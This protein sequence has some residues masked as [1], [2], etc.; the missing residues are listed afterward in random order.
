MLCFVYFSPVCLCQLQNLPDLHGALQRINNLLYRWAG[1]GSPPNWLPFFLHAACG[2]EID[3]QSAL[4]PIYDFNAFGPFTFQPARVNVH[5]FGL[6]FEEQFIFLNGGDP[7]ILHAW[8]DAYIRLR[9]HSAG[10]VPQL[11]FFKKR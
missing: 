8:L 5:G 11:S 4:V 7:D 10:L 6:F 9:F 1:S 2:R 3:Y